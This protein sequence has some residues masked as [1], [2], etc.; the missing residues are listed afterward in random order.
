MEITEAESF[1]IDRIKDQRFKVSILTIRQAICSIWSQDAP[2]IVKD[3]TD[4]GVDHCMRIIKKLK[5]ILSLQDKA[6][7]KEEEIYLLLASIY[8]HDIGM[9]CDISKYSAIKDT[10]EEKFGAEFK[11]E[12]D[13]KTANDYSK[14]EQQ[15]IRKN[16]Q[17][18]TAAWIDFAYLN[19][20]TV[21]AKAV[22][23]VDRNLIKDLIDICKFHSKLPITD[24]PERF[25]ISGSGRKQLVA[26]LLRFG[27]E[28]DIDKNRVNFDTIDTFGYDESNS[29]FWW[30]HDHIHITF[31]KNEILI[32]IDLHPEDAEQHGKFIE[33][34]FIEEFNSKN[35][36]VM[37][38]LHKY[39]ISTFI[40]DNSKV[41]V[42]EYTSKIPQ[43]IIEILLQSEKKKNPS[44]N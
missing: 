26:S 30:L 35:K 37:N 28:L 40:S 27:D 7:L 38:I 12:F 22:E 31:E 13:S 33:K 2:R 4:H 5:E 44:R 16:H 6:F 15:E 25:S 43:E 41:I 14:E 9:Q 21:I 32:K 11:I 8:L 36:S 34:K 19:N 24:C 29:A 18:L 1:F 3:Y 20:K 17:Y 10:A 42:N 39:N 23:T